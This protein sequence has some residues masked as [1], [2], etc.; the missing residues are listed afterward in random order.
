MGRRLLK[1]I[2]RVMGIILRYD[3]FFSFRSGMMIE[4]GDANIYFGEYS[5]MDSADQLNTGYLA[6]HY[7]RRNGDCDGSEWASGHCWEILSSR[8][9]QREDCL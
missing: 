4:R 1:G 3:Q 9:L 2:F 8:K 5:R 6:E 7:S